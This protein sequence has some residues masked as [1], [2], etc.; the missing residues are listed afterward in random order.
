MPKKRVVAKLTGT[1][2]VSVGLASSAYVLQAGA[3]NGQ[4][5]P[6]NGNQNSQ[7]SVHSSTAST[8][9]KPSTD[10]NAGDVHSSVNVSSTAN[11]NDPNGDTQVTV[12]GQPVSLPANG[13][14]T[15]TTNNGN[16]TTTTSVSRSSTGRASN[17]SSSSTQVHVFNQT[18]S[19]VQEGN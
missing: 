11:S 1:A 17:S 5:S 18:N 14:V 19:Q 7:T 13:T 6:A 2:I 12:N 9:P 16:T 3:S 15:K 10:P 8:S 4:S